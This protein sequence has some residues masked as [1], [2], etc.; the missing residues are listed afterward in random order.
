ML[1]GLGRHTDSGVSPVLAVPVVL[2]WGVAVVAVMNVVL[3][4]RRL[5][6]AGVRRDR[7]ALTA[8]Q[9]TRPEQTDY[10]VRWL[11]ESSIWALVLSLPT[12]LVAVSVVAALMGS[13][14]TP[15][16]LGGAFGDLVGVTAVGMSTA[17]LLRHR[18]S[19]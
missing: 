16:L 5:V 14:V 12:V 18:P 9:A 10:H 6:V 11:L 8:A 13:A 4:W 15:R 2:G 19:A 17:L 7:S 1:I 3:P